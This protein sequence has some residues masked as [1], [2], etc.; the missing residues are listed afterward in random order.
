MA[1]NNKKSNFSS[2]PPPGGGGGGGGAF[3]DAA[4]RVAVFPV[5]RSGLYPAMLC[6]AVHV[7]GCCVPRCCVRS[8]ILC[9]GSCDLGRVSRVP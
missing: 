9:F 2:P 7:W 1:D 3:Q 4:F 5:T 6:P 8:G